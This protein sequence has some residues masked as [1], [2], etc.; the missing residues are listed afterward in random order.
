[1]NQAG[2]K[3][4]YVID[5]V[6]L[7]QRIRAGRERMLLTRAE[8]AE[9]LELSDYYLGQLERGERQASLM[10]LLKICECL[11]LSLD[12][13]ILGGTKYP[14]N[15]I[16]N[17]KDSYETKETT[18]RE[19]LYRLLYSCTDEE[20]SLIKKLVKTLLPYIRK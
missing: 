3:S 7:G 11:H 13:L 14:V 9:I 17:R 8:F 15:E 2:Q 5:L 18:G 20:V 12:Y 16:Q 6:A 1:M 4:N 10:V 19:E